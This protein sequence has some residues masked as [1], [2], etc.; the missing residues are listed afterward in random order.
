MWTQVFLLAQPCRQNRASRVSHHSQ[1]VGTETSCEV[2]LHQPPR[3]SADGPPGKMQPNRMDIYF[4]YVLKV[5]VS[6]SAYPEGLWIQETVHS[7]TV[8]TNSRLC[9]T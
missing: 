9:L 7:D 1:P 8:A 2:H 4:I 5:T 3:K 6:T